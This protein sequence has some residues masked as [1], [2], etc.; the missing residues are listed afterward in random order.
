MRLVA[1]LL[2]FA[3]CGFS[4]ARNVTV[5][6]KFEKPHSE[7]SLAA[8]RQELKGLLEPA[9]VAVD[10]MLKSDMPESPEFSELVVFDMKGSCSMI[11]SQAWPLGALSDERGPLAMAY[12][13]DGQVLHFGEVECDR[14]RRCLQRVTGKGSP[15]RHQEVFGAALAIVMA[16]EIYHMM[17]GEKA[18]TKLGITK[19]SL[20]AND[21]FNRQLSIPHA[22]SEALRRG[23]LAATP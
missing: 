3:A 11:S 9:G 18:H 2:C 15:E 4:A 20:S 22:V 8:L 10:L 16:H 17:V 23:L 5:L 7:V 6:M 19:E 13:S 14:V 21:L 12:V 1:M